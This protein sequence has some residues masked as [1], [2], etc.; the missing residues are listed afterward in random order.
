MLH[1]SWIKHWK[2]IKILRKKDKENTHL[3]PKDKKGSLRQNDNS[4]RSVLYGQQ[5]D[6]PWSL[7]LWMT[8]ALRELCGYVL[9]A[10]EK[11]RGCGTALGTSFLT[12]ELW[13][14]ETS[15]A[16]QWRDGL[17]S[18][19]RQKAQ[20]L[21]GPCWDRQRYWFQ[22]HIARHELKVVHISAM[23][24]AA[25]QYKYDKLTEHLMGWWPPSF[26]VENEH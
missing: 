6:R 15:Q 11:L 13:H 7:G 14:H 12:F 24:D 25:M 3:R 17:Q 1:N 2:L 5:W 16:S 23:N 19:H 8:R 9:E 18:I 22:S 4:T 10:H 21:V 26:N 20:N